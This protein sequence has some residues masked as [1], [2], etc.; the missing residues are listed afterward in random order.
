MLRGTKRFPKSNA[1]KQQTWAPQ[2]LASS[3][4][5]NHPVNIDVNAGWENSLSTH[6]VMLLT[7]L[8]SLR[9]RSTKMIL[10][11]IE[12]KLLKSAAYQSRRMRYSCFAKT[13]DSAF[14]Q[15]YRHSLALQSFIRN[16]SAIYDNFHILEF[17][18]ENSMAHLNSTMGLTF[19]FQDCIYRK[20]N[21][22][23]FPQKRSLTQGKVA[24]MWKTFTRRGRKADDKGADTIFC[25]ISDLLC[26]SPP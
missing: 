23:H 8:H 15:N 6:P 21:P 3:P 26:R 10:K 1:R 14:I 22:I 18:N 17:A 25:N 12:K 5:R 9:V 7:P 20:L 19:R 11:S 2:S 13:P 16:M 4:H 24:E